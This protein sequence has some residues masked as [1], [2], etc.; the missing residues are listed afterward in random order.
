MHLPKT[1]NR[2]INE[3]QTSRIN[4]K[5]GPEARSHLPQLLVSDGSGHV[6]EIPELL[7]TGSGF[8]DPVVPSRDELIPLPY[9]SDLFELPDRVAIGYDPATEQ[10]VEV[11]TYKGKPVYP[12]A[13][14]MAP[15]YLQ[16]YRS[17]YLTPEGAVR[18]PLYCYTAVGWMNGTFY[19]PAMRIDPDRRQDLELFDLKEIEKRAVER[20]KQFKGNR[21]VYHLV[22]NCTLTYGCPAARNFVL[23]RWECPVPTSAACNAACVGCI[24]EQ[25]PESGIVAS[26]ER[27]QFLPTVDEIVEFTVPHLEKAERAVVSFGQGCEGEPL[28]AGPLIEEAIRAIRKRTSRGIIN[29][30]TNASRPEVVDRLCRAGLDSIRVS[31]NSAQKHFYEAYYQPRQYGF[32]QVIQ[33]MRLMHRHGRWVSINYLVFPGLTDHPDEIA[34]LSRLIQ[35]VEPDMLQTRNLN[36]DPHWYIEALALDTLSPQQIGMKRWVEL[37]RKRFPRLKLGYFNPPKEAMQRGES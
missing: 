20:L 16:L 28:M 15:A 32:E 30:N 8:L 23:G 18:L 25:P 3:H 29:I 12:V 17:A 36:I 2:G 35:E 5:T 31:M 7:M 24:S 26:H 34:A 19:V 9:G 14:F 10:Y 1:P 13:A 33:T 21:L 22:E 27:L 37:M 6:F 11:H 4:R